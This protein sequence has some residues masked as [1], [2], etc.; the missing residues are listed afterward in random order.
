VAVVLGLAGVLHI[1]LLAVALAIALQAVL[2]TRIEPVQ[3]AMWVLL[4]G[5]L[6]CLLLPEVLYVRDEFDGSAL[7]RMNT[8]VQARLPGA[9]CCSGWAV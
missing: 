1:V 9:G 3:R 5:G 8:V 6:G 4:A 2:V 7:Y